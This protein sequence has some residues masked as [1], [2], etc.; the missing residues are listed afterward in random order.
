MG[1]S[2]LVL[3][4]MLTAGQSPAPG[5]AVAGT[6]GE[7]IPFVQADVGSMKQDELIAKYKGKAITLSGEVLNVGRDEDRGSDYYTLV[8]RRQ[9][10]K[11]VLV[12][13]VYFA[14]PFDDAVA[15][16]RKRAKQ[17][18]GFTMDVK[19]TCHNILPGDGGGVVILR[20]AEVVT[21]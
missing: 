2:A 6:A 12:A 14:D 9:G 11:A 4:A 15:T 13:R 3:S 1:L 20:R 8:L 5:Q 18:P 19:A 17:K 21:K 16:L 7:A 10:P